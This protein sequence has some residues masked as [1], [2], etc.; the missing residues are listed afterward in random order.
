LCKSNVIGELCD[1]CKENSWGL[2]SG[3]GCEECECDLVGSESPQCNEKTGQCSCKPGVGGKHCDQCLPGHWNLT[4]S[5]CIMCQCES[6]STLTLKS[7]GYSCDPVTGQCSCIQGVRGK[8]CGECDARWVLV[9][10]V[11]C[12]QCD[13][14]VNTLL[15][16]IDELT[17]KFDQTEYYF[18]NVNF[19]LVSRKLSNLDNN[20]QDYLDAV[21]SVEELDLIKLIHFIHVSSQ[22]LTEL[23]NLTNA[24]FSEKIK[25]FD[26]LQQEASRLFREFENHNRTKELEYILDD[27]KRERDPRISFSKLANYESIVRRI[28][29]N[30]KDDILAKKTNSD[31]FTQYNKC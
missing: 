26:E 5:G 19:S 11:G 6:G 22:N 14:C 9:N 2:S 17:E 31:I 29:R 27:L 21:T 3:N 12:K 24:N 7:G 23:V 25:F 15:D 1:K 10:N 28:K 8:T 18:R 30:S 20:Y 13:T 16:E 4:E